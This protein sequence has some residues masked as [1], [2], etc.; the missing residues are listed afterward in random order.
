MYSIK[1]EVPKIEDSSE[2]NHKIEEILQ[3]YKEIYKEEN[4]QIIK[5]GTGLKLEDIV[6]SRKEQK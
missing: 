3:I 4:E 6:A 5:E 1:D 2:R